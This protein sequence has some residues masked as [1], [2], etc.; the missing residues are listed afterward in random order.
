MVRVPPPQKQRYLRSF[1]GLDGYYR[2]FIKE[3]SKLASPLFGLLD[4]EPEFIWSKCCQETLDILK[5]KLTTGLILWG[6]NWALPFH[7]H[8]DASHKAIGSSLC[9]IDAK[10]PYAIY[11][12]SKNL[13]KV[14]LSYTVTEKELLVVVNSLNKFTHYIIG[15]QTFVH[16]DHVVAKYLM[17]KPDVNA[18]IIIWL[19]LL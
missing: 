1:L 10:S 12:I 2:R 8:D 6:P 5:S 14:E 16:I 11:F 3:F 18:R 13:S 4:K 7:L 15:Y 9:Q 17:N 19:L